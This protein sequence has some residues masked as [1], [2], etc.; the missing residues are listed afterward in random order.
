MFF[1]FVVPLSLKQLEIIKSNKQK[2]QTFPP[3][4]LMSITETHKILTVIM[5]Y[6]W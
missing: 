3:H 4:S 5:I 6:P 1:I 2:S